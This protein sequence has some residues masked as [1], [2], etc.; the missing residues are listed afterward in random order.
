MGRLLSV[1]GQTV[2]MRATR[3][4]AA[5]VVLACLF[6][7]AAD[8]APPVFFVALGRTDDESSLRLRFLDCVGGGENEYELVVG[9]GGAEIGRQRLPFPQVEGNVGYDVETSIPLAEMTTESDLA[10]SVSPLGSTAVE[11][12]P[13]QLQ[14]LEAG[15]MLVSGERVRDEDVDRALDNQCPGQT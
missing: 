7:C 14:D 3:A 2:G 10:V 8:P 12:D 11:L 15:Q 4:A 6:G 9:V 1:P 13:V 5:A